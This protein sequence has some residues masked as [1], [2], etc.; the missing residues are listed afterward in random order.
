MAALTNRICEFAGRLAKDP[1]TFPEERLLNVR[2]GELF[3]FAAVIVI[4]ECPIP[5]GPMY[6][7]VPV[8]L[9]P[10]FALRTA[11]QWYLQSPA[12]GEGSVPNPILS[13]R[14]V[15]FGVNVQVACD[16]TGCGGGGGVGVGVITGPE[17]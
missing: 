9:S 1:I 10:H 6:M 12:V 5:F 13:G 14:P 17:V 11:V 15:L 7:H 4:I 16:V 2:L 8:S 3:A